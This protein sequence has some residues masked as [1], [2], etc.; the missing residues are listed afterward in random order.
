M[1]V[2][3]AVFNFIFLKGIILYPLENY[4]FSLMWYLFFV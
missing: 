3:I 4:F 1:Y 2:Y